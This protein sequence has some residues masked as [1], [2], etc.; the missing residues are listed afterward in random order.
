[1]IRALQLARRGDGYR[2]MAAAGALLPAD[3]PAAGKDRDKVI[4][5][6][7]RQVLDQ[8]EFFGKQVVSCLPAHLV[9]YK[10]LRLPRMPRE[11]LTAA[12]EWEARDRLQLGNDQAVVQFL[13]LVKC[14][15]VMKSVRK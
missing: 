6:T 9:Q 8:G 1:M 15:R 11:E 12:V 10:N 5:Q 14:V 7:L 3:I 2:V 13:M 4:E